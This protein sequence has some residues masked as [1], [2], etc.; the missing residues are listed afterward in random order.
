MFPG[1]GETAQRQSQLDGDPARPL[2]LGQGLVPTLASRFQVRHPALDNFEAMQRGGDKHG[3]SFRRTHAGAW[4]SLGSMWKVSVLDTS[5]PTL[6]RSA[7][8]SSGLSV[9]VRL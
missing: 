6:F 1:V 2:R 3:V 4:S 8:A 7:A 5:S 9:S